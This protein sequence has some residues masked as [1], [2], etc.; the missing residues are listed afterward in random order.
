MQLILFPAIPQSARRIAVKLPCSA[1]GLICWA[2][3]DLTDFW[4]LSVI[5]IEPHCAMKTHQLV[6]RRHCT[7]LGQISKQG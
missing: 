5:C 7:D 2:Q 6:K 3:K 4:E 1:A